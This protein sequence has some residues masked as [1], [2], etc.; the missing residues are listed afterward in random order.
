MGKLHIGNFKERPVTMQASRDA[1]NLMLRQK[2]S[3]P[4]PDIARPEAL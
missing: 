1:I 2:V 4:E 3:W